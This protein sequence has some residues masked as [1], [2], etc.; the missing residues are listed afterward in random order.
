MG[1][2]SLHSGLCPSGTTQATTLHQTP[3]RRGR[4]PQATPSPGSLALKGAG[5]GGAL[6]IGLCKRQAWR[7]GGVGRQPAGDPAPSP[8][9]TPSRAWVGRAPPMQDFIFFVTSQVSSIRS[10]NTQ[11]QPLSQPQLSTPVLAR[12]L[13]VQPGTHVM[14]PYPPVWQLPASCAAVST[15]SCCFCCR[16]RCH[17]SLKGWRN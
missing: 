7:G 3:L 16:R 17:R 2:A 1:H 15:S 6:Q 14:S 9:Q 8:K 4:V 11:C 12:A 13:L 10:Q 5:R